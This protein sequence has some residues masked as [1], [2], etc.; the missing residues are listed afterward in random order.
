MEL[1]ILR[2]LLGGF[3]A[4]VASFFVLGFLYGNPAVA[5]IYKNAEGSPAL[6]KWESNPK[7]IFMQYVGMLIQC[8]LWALVFAFVR[9]ALP[10]ATICAGLVF[11]LIIM[12][13]KIFPRLFDM[14]IQT[15][16]PGKLLA[17]EFING[18]IGG[19][20]VGIVLA[21]VIG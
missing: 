17:T 20:L 3:L 7:Y 12:V 11:G 2:T 15:Y 1:D 19:F 8:L 14:W 13:M 10:A 5:K 16:Y 9:S 18:S 6:K 4:S 21:Y